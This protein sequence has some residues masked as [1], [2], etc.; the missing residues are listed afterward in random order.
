M[1]KS[2]QTILLIS[3]D[4]Q[5][6]D[7]IRSGLPASGFS[8]TTA[9]D[10]SDGLSLFLKLKPDFVILS[11][12]LLSSM[13]LMTLSDICGADPY[14]KVIAIGASTDDS[15][16]ME[17]IRHGAMDYIKKPVEKRNIIQSIERINNRRRL[18][19]IISE[20]DTACVHEEDKVLIFG[21]DT[22]KLP[23]IINQAACNARVVCRDIQML[24]MALGE[25][26]LNAIEHGNLEI[27]MEE[28]ASATNKGDYWKLL[29]DRMHDSRYSARTVTLHIHMNRK[30]LVYTV[31]DQG[32]GFNHKALL[33]SD[34]KSHGG[35]GLGLFLV[36]NFF[37]SI[38]FNDRGNSVTLV[39]KRPRK[40]VR[41]NR[42]NAL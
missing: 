9:H 13:S 27:T 15:L 26:V 35:S 8:L 11:V 5:D 7:D 38:T 41:R 24:K 33:N 20:P 1:G 25:I 17:C 32:K 10:S 28:K 36:K 29:N 23:Y 40:D 34:L 22:Q 39:Y 6:L 2:R 14:A 3:E 42:N 16:A 18:L 37:T 12:S 31:T 30:E 21:N 19:E 4:P